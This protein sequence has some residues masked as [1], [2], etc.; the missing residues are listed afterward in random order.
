M[1]RK[2]RAHPLSSEN[3]AIPCL[4]N[5]HTRN[6]AKVHR[7]TS[8]TIRR[9]VCQVASLEVQLRPT[10][11]PRRGTAAAICRRVRDLQVRA[12]E[13]P[14]PYRKLLGA[15]MA[16]RARRRDQSAL[17]HTHHIPSGVCRALESAHRA[18]QFS[19]G[20]RL[21]RTRDSHPAPGR[22]SHGARVSR[23]PS[24]RPWTN[25][26]TPSPIIA[27]TTCRARVSPLL[28]RRLI[29]GERMMLAHVYLK[30]GCIV[31]RHSH[32]NEQLTYILEGALRFWIGEDESEEVIVVR[33]GEVLDIPSNVPHKAEALEDTL[34]VDVFC[35]PRQDWLDGTD[36]SS[37]SSAR[38]V[39]QPRDAEPRRGAERWDE[40][41]P[42]RRE[43]CQ[44]AGD[45][46]VIHRRARSS[47][48]RASAS[49]AEEAPGSIPC[50]AHQNPRRRWWR[51][52]GLVVSL[53]ISAVG[54][55]RHPAR[56][57]AAGRRAARSW[58]W[59]TANRWDRGT[60]SP[61]NPRAHPL[62]RCEAMPSVRSCCRSCSSP[63]WPAPYA[64]RAPSPRAQ[65]PYSPGGGA[66][67]QGRMPS[68]WCRRSAPSARGP[69]HHA[70]RASRRAANMELI[71]EVTAHAAQCQAPARRQRTRQLM[72]CSTGPRRAPSGSRRIPINR[73][74]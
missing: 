74:L 2:A 16:P 41:L 8:S 55:R 48:D 36:A 3:L 64:E 12:T 23:N 63:R 31:P 47:T 65:T 44:I 24:H 26:R 6:R 54:A 38:P 67:R 69:P 22:M 30:K 1:R 35:P 72:V 37:G 73:A 61:S 17:Q 42:A 49:E 7:T 43:P 15:G 68:S 51:R 18:L 53:P 11:L 9:R 33:A 21:P 13:C 27:G 40:S 57:R 10:C 5:T 52:G 62:I 14:K 50:G 19:S 45:P 25:P 29:T 34:D 66:A 59:C 32:E 70:A 28:D 60:L 71:D 20:W 4:A 46:G 39:E 58:C 56:R